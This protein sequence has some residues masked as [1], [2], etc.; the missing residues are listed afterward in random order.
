MTEWF[1]AYDGAALTLRVPEDEAGALLCSAFYKLSLRR[2]IAKREGG[3]RDAAL[4]VSPALE[5]YIQNRGSYLAQR[6]RLGMEI[7]NREEK[8]LPLFREYQSI[9]NAAMARPL[10]ERQMWDSFFLCAMKRSANFS[11]PGSGKTASVLGVYAYLK[12]R[13]LTKRLLVVCP[14]NAF[15]S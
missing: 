7:K 10:Q 15:G 13:G 5:D 12:S 6:F 2:Y 3:R 1:L 4:A 9:V 11:V 8:L 14:K